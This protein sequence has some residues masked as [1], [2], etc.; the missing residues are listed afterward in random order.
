MTRLHRAVGLVILLLF[1]GT[2]AWMRLAFPDA[3][4]PDPS[5]RFLF[6]ANHVYL[7]FAALLNLVV[8]AYPI[9]RRRLRRTQLVGSLLLL[10]APGLLTLAFWLEPPAASP[11]RPLTVAG[12]AL[13]AAGVA[14]HVIAA[15]REER[16]ERSLGP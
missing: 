8:G 6:R 7:L 5:V 15:T 1:L 12:V 3:W 2:G 10:F 4:S 11:G 14:L 16:A 9:P 13:T